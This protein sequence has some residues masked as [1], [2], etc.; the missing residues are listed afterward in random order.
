MDLHDCWLEPEHWHLWRRRLELERRA[1]NLTPA[2]RD[3]LR[4]LLAFVGDDGLFPSDAAVAALAGHSVS[5]VRRARNDAR[6]LGMLSWRRTRKLVD[7]R[8][9]QGSNAYEVTTP[10][11]PVCPD[12]QIERRRKAVSK[13]EAPKPT[14]G[15]LQAPEP[16]ASL[17][18]IARLMRDRHAS[19]WQTRQ[20][21]SLKCPAKK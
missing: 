6:E 20:I 12:S 13:Q 4:A 3:A 19:A 1:G 7:G 8:N 9:R 17:P 11:S 10:S 16:T 15:S 21:S 2:R 5:T 18:E 14:R